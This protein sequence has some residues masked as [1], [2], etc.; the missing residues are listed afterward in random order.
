MRLFSPELLALPTEDSITA[1]KRPFIPPPLDLTKLSSPMQHQS[2][3]ANAFDFTAFFSSP[4]L[5]I[6]RTTSR[7]SGKASDEQEAQAAYWSQA[8]TLPP[9][10]EFG[11]RQRPARSASGAAHSFE[12]PM[13]TRYVGRAFATHPSSTTSGTTATT[14]SKRARRGVEGLEAWR[15]MADHAWSTGRQRRQAQSGRPD[16]DRYVATESRHG[17]DG[18]EQST[19][20]DDLA[21]LESRHRALERDLDMIDR[22]YSHLFVTQ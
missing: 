18:K 2:S 1:T 17:S 22:K 15:E 9:P 19:G 3:T 8:T 7:A 20:I 11:S 5:S 14:T 13:M 6:L 4:G 12:T 10:S 21:V 16:L